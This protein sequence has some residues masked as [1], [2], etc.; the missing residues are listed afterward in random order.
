MSAALLAKLKI[1]K[2]PDVLEKVELER[3]NRNSRPTQSISNNEILELKKKL[4]NQYM[5]V[6]YF[7][8]KKVI[9]WLMRVKNFLKL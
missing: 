4:D 6:I 2:Q 3:Q 1:K 7:K 5:I 9:V 8:F